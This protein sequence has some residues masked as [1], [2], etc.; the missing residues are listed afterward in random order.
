MFTTNNHM[1]APSKKNYYVVGLHTNESDIHDHRY[2]ALKDARDAYLSAVN[3]YPYR[4]VHLY[5]A[6]PLSEEGDLL[7]K[8]GFY[9]VRI[10]DGKS[11][12][13]TVAAN[14]QLSKTR[15]AD[16]LNKL[17]NLS[18]MLD[19]IGDEIFDDGTDR[20]D[21]EQNEKFSNAWKTIKYVG[22]KLADI[23]IPGIEEAFLNDLWKNCWTYG[24]SNLPE[25]GL[26]HHE[27]YIAALEELLADDPN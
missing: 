22:H 12:P 7:K 25:Y 19:H 11:F 23:S 6:Y 27:H 2:T 26:W 1:E 3:Q 15:R 9:F 4:E 21:F 20:E 10:E 5:K 8:E 16:I 14:N 18:V 24:G 17:D 13:S